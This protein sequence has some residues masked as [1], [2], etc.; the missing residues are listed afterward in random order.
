[1][2]H[3]G[4]STCQTRGRVLSRWLKCIGLLIDN[5]IVPVI[6]FQIFNLI[7]QLGAANLTKISQ[8]DKLFF[9]NLR[10][11]LLSDI[12]RISDF[13]WELGVGL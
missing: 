6:V 5:T 10:V 13:F 1:M 9:Q 8:I 3:A 4:I 11:G 12:F 2:I 7:A